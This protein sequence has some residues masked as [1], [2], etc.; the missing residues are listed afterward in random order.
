MWWSDETYRLFGVSPQDFKA[1][2]EHYLSFLTPASAELVSEQVKSILTDHQPYSHCA[3]LQ[4]GRILHGRGFLI[5]DDA[6]QPV[7]LYGTIQAVDDILVLQDQLNIF[8][9]IVT[10]Q[11]EMIGVF[12][13]A[14]NKILFHN[15]SLNAFLGYEAMNTDYPSLNQLHPEETLHDLSTIFIPRLIHDKHVTS[16]LIFIKKNKEQKK[17]VVQ[18][19]LHEDSLSGELIAS[20]IFH[21]PQV[22]QAQVKEEQHRKEQLKKYKRLAE[23]AEVASGIA[24]EI[25][26]PLTV[27]SS[28]IQMLATE[29][30]LLGNH[31]VKNRLDN[32]SD[33]IFELSRLISAINNLSQQE[34]SERQPCQLV[35]FFRELH[36]ELSFLVEN[37]NVRLEY[38]VNIPPQAQCR[39]HVIQCKQA[40]YNLIHNSLEA[41]A[42]CDIQ[43]PVI[44]LQAYQNDN[45][46]HVKISDNG[47]G[48]PDHLIDHVFEHFYTTKADGNGIGLSFVKTIIDQHQG[49]ITV[50]SQD[51]PGAYFCIQLPL[52]TVKEEIR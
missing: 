2:Y 44:T 1:S 20:V 6:Q 9:R 28:E 21:D 38:Y 30:A 22:C 24:H 42:E 7:K 12:S 4:N 40:V 25:N 36:T 14:H 37:Q 33:K 11:N 46:L 13:I 17:V 5:T 45:Q 34:T 23:V 32:I 51:N 18:A 41:I 16:E 43:Q 47:P 52:V 19:T 27:I 29:P 50:A 15:A 48:I 3:E 10:E 31:E 35:G 26:Q 39:L 49:S 8:Q